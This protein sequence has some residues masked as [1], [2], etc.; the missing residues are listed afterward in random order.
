MPIFSQAPR[1]VLVKKCSIGEHEEEEI[2]VFLGDIEDPAALRAIGK[3]LTS[4]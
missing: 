4:G 2:G 1:H 3:R